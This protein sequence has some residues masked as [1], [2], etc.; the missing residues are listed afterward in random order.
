MNFQQLRIVRET[1]RQ[2][3]N[4]TETGKALFTSQ[5]GISKGLKELEDELGV[6][7]FSRFGKRLIGLTEA[8]RDLLK[9][10]DRI[11]LDAEN[12]KRVALQFSGHKKGNLTVATTHT[13]AR[14]V[15]PNIIKR[16]MLDVPEVHLSLHQ[17][18]PKEIAEL[19]LNGDADIGIATETLALVPE[20][21]SFPCYEWEHGVVV[22]KDPPLLALEKVTL[23]DLSKFPIITYH[24]SFTG[25]SHVDH[26][27]RRANLEPDIVITAMDAD[28][29][30][31]Y[32][33][34]GLGIGVVSS[35]AFC[36]ER[37]VSLALIPA[38]H[39]FGS[40]FARIAV[41]RGHYLRGYAYDFIL[42]LAPDLTEADLRNKI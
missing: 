32:V 24:P 20:L 7:I 16:F 39:L 37:D 34:L 15:L 23:E 36:P 40:N 38:G 11:L 2:N 4:L 21:I 31:T 14:Y 29:I 42:K 3:F 19:L 26:A 8:G 12:I 18:S 9:V 25:R 27:F 17:G 6:E 33:G 10:V 35:L 13:Q 5:S 22:Q 30:K 41:R 28:V 1:V